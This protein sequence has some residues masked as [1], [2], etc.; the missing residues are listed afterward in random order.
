MRKSTM[1]IVIGAALVALAGCASKAETI[2][3]AGGAAVG[4]GVTGGSALGTLGG[5]AVG[6]GAGKVYDDKHNNNQ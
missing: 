3:T 4:Y 6:Y 1:A 2:G 5:A